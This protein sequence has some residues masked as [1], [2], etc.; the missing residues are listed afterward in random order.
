MGLNSG[1]IRR[2]HPH[3]PVAW[4]G[5][6]GATMLFLVCLAS[7][8]A[9]LWGTALGRGGYL[10]NSISEWAYDVAFSPDGRFLAYCNSEG[11]FVLD[12]ATYQETWRLD[13]ES[14]NEG[15]RRRWEGH[16]G[17]VLSIA[18]HPDGHWLASGGEDGTARLWDLDTGR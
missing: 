5:L 2:V 6:L 15:G 7:D 13:Y 18:F 17:A 14:Y 1:T 11:V 16:T 10:A 9:P 12:A 8:H 3:K 4:T